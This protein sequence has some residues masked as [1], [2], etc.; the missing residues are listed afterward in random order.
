MRLAIDPTRVP[1]RDAS[2]VY[3]LESLPVLLR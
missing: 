2:I 3:G 1:F